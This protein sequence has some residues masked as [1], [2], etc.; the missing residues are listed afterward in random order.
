VVIGR[1]ENAMPPLLPLLA[2]LSAVGGILCIL[3]SALFGVSDLSDWLLSGAEGLFALG[4]IVF[5]VYVLSGIVSDARA[6]Q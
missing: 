2:A 6:A 3:L 5:T 4:V 1:K